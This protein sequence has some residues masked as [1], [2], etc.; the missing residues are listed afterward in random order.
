MQ[1][2][3]GLLSVVNPFTYWIDGSFVTNKTEPEDIDLALLIENGAIDKEID[4]L[5]PFLT[6]GGSLDE[7]HIDAHVIPIYPEN[8]S[9]Y[10][11]TLLRLNYF[12]EWFSQDRLN[13]P[14]GFLEIFSTK[15]DKR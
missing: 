8:D 12:R 4:Y 14:K 3:Q 7:Y 10:E 1:Y 13:N 5:L 2:N 6:V 11:N 9:R 15:M